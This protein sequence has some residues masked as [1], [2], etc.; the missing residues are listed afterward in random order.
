MIRRPPRSTLFPYTTLFRSLVA[1]RLLDVDAVGKDLPL[2][3]L[4]QDLRGAPTPA[5]RSPAL[6]QQ[7]ARIEETERFA[8]EMRIGREVGGQIA[9]DVRRVRP[10]RAEHLR[11]DLR[12]QRS[13]APEQKQRPAPCDE[14][15]RHLEAARPIDPRPG[16]I[17]TEPVANV[18]S[19]GVAVT[20]VARQLVG[21]AEG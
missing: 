13:R 11:A 16:G 5:C 9:L 20:L 3:L 10:H 21:L 18:S 19:E 17:R 4:N 2:A 15:Q 12:G 7:H 14:P 1:R 6:R 8:G